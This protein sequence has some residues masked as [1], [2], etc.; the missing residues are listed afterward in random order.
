M[1]HTYILLFFAAL[2]LAG[3]N[4]E[5]RVTALFPMQVNG[6]YLYLDRAGKT[7]IGPKYVEATCF[8]DDIALVA[9]NEDAW[10]YID[11]TGKNLFNTS[12]K[13][14]TTFNEDLAF[15]VRKNEAPAV[16]DKSGKVQFT[17]NVAERADNFSEGLAA[18]SSLTPDGELWGFVNREGKV[19][20]APQFALAGFFAENY[21]SVSNKDGKWG[22]I[23]KDGKTVIA[24][25]YDNVSSFYSNAAR[26]LVNGK[27]GAIDLKG[28]MLIQPAYDNIQSD[29]GAFAVEQG[30]KWGWIDRSGKNI[31]PMQY[32]DVLP[33]NGS[34]YAAVRQG[35]K[36]G[37]IDKAN[38]MVIEPKYEFAF[39]FDGNMAMVG[40]KMQYGFIDKEGKTVIPLTYG[41]PNM[42]YIISYFSKSSA[43]SEV[44]SDVNTPVHVAYQWLTNFYQMRFEKAKLLSTEDTRVLMDQFAGLTSYMS[45]SSRK[46]MMNVKVGIRDSKVDGDHANVIYVL[47]DTP[48]KEQVIN[49]VNKDGRWLIQ[50]SKNDVNGSEHPEDAVQ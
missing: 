39:G 17:L 44:R 41:A 50:F 5:S 36:W 43:F 2:C 42:D 4:S 34:D 9:E 10:S 45:D 7:V 23:D 38:K 18:F 20:I 15:V 35:E 25:Q 6:K 3:C 37:Y 14:A 26:V 24:Y 33:F 48:N 21:C 46:A 8:R 29:G 40:Q 47:S 22:F 19:V 11:K 16:I 28:K 30:G 1:K 27:W 49:L 13:E 12:Y 32:D 31:I